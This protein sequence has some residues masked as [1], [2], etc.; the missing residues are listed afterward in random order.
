MTSATAGVC[1]I[2]ML[3]KLT[4]G[5]RIKCFVVVVVDLDKILLEKYRTDGQKKKMYIIL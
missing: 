1:V 2:I 4:G 5:C 3:K